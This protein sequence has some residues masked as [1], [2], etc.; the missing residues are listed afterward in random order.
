MRKSN[1][2]LV[3][4]GVV[5]TIALLGIVVTKAIAGDLTGTWDIEYEAY[6][7]PPEGYNTGS[8]IM[9]ITEQLGGVFTGYIQIPEG[10]DA[11]FINGAVQNKQ[12]TFINGED[13]MFTGALRR[14]GKFICGTVVDL[15]LSD[16][17]DYC[18]GMFKA[19]RR[20]D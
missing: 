19:S 11:D 20:R 15:P 14:G 4:C 16:T 1:C 17:P 12:I 6:C 8:G 10:H 2:K 13:D 3:L 5:I 7:S 18:A 9:V